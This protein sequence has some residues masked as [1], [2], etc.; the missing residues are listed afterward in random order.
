VANYFLTNPDF[1][2]LGYPVHSSRA[3]GASQLVAVVAFLGCRPGK[4]PAVAWATFFSKEKPDFWLIFKEE[5]SGTTAF[6]SQRKRHSESA[7]KLF[8][9]FFFARSSRRLRKKTS[10]SGFFCAVF[11]AVVGRNINNEGSVLPP[12]SKLIAAERAFSEFCTHN[13]S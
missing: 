10:E 9:A 11:F 3:R 4:R 12:Y 8:R 2:G 13:S 6:F 1:R 5:L 7:P